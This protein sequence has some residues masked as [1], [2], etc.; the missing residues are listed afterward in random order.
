LTIAWTAAADAN[1]YFLTL[2]SLQ[3]RIFGNRYTYTLDANRAEHSGTPDP[4][5]SY[6]LVAVDG[7]GQSSTAVSG[8][9][10]NA[11]PAAPVATLIAGAV[12]DL[13]AT[14]TSTPPAD[15]WRNEF[16]FKRDGT[17]VATVFSTGATYQYTMPN[18]ADIGYHSWTVVVRQEDLFAQFSATHTPAAVAFDPLTLGHLRSQARYSD[19]TGNTDA[20]LKAQLADG[21]T[22]SGGISYAA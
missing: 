2:D 18:A 13:Y 22:T 8:T 17:T 6:S 11:A 14:V 5:I 19:S 12:T 9:A 3:R 21:V 7:F 16:V 1:Y 10:T 20:D 15:F 4:A